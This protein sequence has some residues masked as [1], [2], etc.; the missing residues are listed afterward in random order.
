M[1]HDDT[2]KTVDFLLTYVTLRAQFLAQMHYLN[3][4]GKSPQVDATYE[5]SRL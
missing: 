1:Q 3:K 4:L 2:L 5:I